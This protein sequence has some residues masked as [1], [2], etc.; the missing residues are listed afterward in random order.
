[1]G[2]RDVNSRATSIT[3]RPEMKLKAQ[4]PELRLGIQKG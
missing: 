4:G 1:M 3:W 2:F